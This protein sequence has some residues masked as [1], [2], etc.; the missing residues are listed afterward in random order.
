MVFATQS[1]Y[2]GRQNVVNSRNVMRN[3]SLNYLENIVPIGFADKFNENEN[4]GL[5]KK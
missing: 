3:T 4:N 2:S 5:T 1:P